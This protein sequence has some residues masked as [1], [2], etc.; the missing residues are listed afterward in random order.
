MISLLIT[1][2]VILLVF[3]VFWYI[4]SLLPLPPPFAMIGQI[5]LAVLLLLVLLNFLLPVAGLGWG[6]GYH[7]IR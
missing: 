7:G 2:L 1:L 3:G 6:G 5:V 4:I